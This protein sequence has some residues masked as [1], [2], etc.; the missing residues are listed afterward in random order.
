MKTVLECIQSG[1]KYL[2][3]RGVDGAR[4]NMEWLVARQMELRAFLESNLMRQNYGKASI[5][6]LVFLQHRP[7]VKVVVQLLRA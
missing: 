1:A 2:R 6:F 3:D 4:R 7:S 5:I